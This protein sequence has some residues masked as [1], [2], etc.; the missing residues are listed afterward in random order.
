[1]LFFYILSWISLVVQLSFIVISIAAGLYYIAEFVEEYTVLSK[2]IIRIFSLTT[3]AIHIGLLLF[4]DLPLTM[5]MSGILA[6]AAHL[7]ILQSFPYVSIAS[8][9]FIMTILLLILNHYFAFTYFAKHMY[10][11]S[12]VIA[13]FTLCLWLVPFSLFVS[14][15]ANENVLPTTF[16]SERA[17]VDDDVISNYFSGRRK[18]SSL[19]S[20]FEYAKEYLMPQRRNKKSF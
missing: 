15:S 6:Q 7:Y 20:V 5:N 12:E 9:G 1:M 17:R 18:R 19:L 4:E 11:F 2:K 8:P 10:N 14:L 3:C 16:Q 13:Y